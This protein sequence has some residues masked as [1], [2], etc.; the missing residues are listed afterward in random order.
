MK[1]YYKYN[2]DKFIK[3]LV[4]KKNK[5]DSEKKSDDYHR[6][7]TQGLPKQK[8]IK[9]NNYVF[10]NKLILNSNK[11]NKFEKDKFIINQ[12]LY[13]LLNQKKILKNILPKEVDYN[14]QF[15][16]M[17]IINKE[18][19]PLNRF[20]KKNLTQ[21]STLI[22]QEIELLFGKNISL[23]NLQNF[24]NIYQN[25]ENRIQYKTGEKYN[26]LLKTF[27]KKENKENSLDQDLSK[28]REKKLMHRR[29]ILEKFKIALKECMF[30]FLRLKITK[31]FFWE[32]LFNETEIKYEDGLYIFNSIKDGD[33]SS[34]ER[35]IKK[36]YRFVVFKD[37][38]NQTPLH[39]CAKRNIYQVVKLCVSRLADVNAQDIY[40][41]TP[42][43]NAAQSGN[44]EFVCVILF[45]FADPSIEDKN[46]KRAVDYAK[47]Y[48]IEY[49]LKYARII[50]IFNRM[51]NSLRNFDSFVLRALRHLFGKE[52]GINY[53]PWL[54]INEKIL[55][56]K[57]DI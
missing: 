34:I 32:I 18:M 7:V 51:M 9:K 23:V 44:L 4:T 38:F 54:E 50:H 2:N 48:M 25:K 31:E 13:P 14:T 12:D 5:G 46:G 11:K 16:I 20:Q 35:E 43:I 10:E 53:E 26:Q 27:I 40:G 41:R 8:D 47:N 24:S 52:L 37:E 21:H 55:N 30:K 1:I 3:N 15:T 28:E 42:L 19:H 22:S 36:N 49:A 57:D 56:K 39:I 29:Y 33:V 17:D 45:N 6:I